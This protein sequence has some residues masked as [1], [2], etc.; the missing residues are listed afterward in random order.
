MKY[1]R[2]CL[3]PDSRPGTEFVHGV[4]PAC[5]FRL[6]STKSDWQNRKR[7]LKQVVD[8][9]KSVGHVSGHDSILGV[10]GGKDSTRLALFARDALGLNPLLVSVTY[11]PLQMT[12]V[13]ANNLDNLV[14]LG[15]DV[16]QTSPSPITWGKFMRSTFLESANWAKSTEL[17]LFSG[18]PQIAIEN[19]IKLI[20]WG[21]N[22][23][24]QLGALETLGNE[25]WDGNSLR[26]MNTLRG[27]DRD[28]LLGQN[29]SRSLISPYIYPSPSEFE[30]HS[31]QI[32]FLGWAMGNWG[33][34]ENGLVA[35]LAGLQGRSDSPINTSDLLNITSLDEDW[36]ILNQMIKYYKYGFGRATDYVNEW[37]RA[38]RLTRVEGIALVQKYDGACADQYIE[39]FSKF[40]NITVEEFWQTVRK[41]TNP[42]LFDLGSAGRPQPLFKVGQS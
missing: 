21:E 9:R 10:S 8:S 29:V 41:F 3:Q 6:T 13:G 25:G 11:P 16:Y 17:A 39:S 30:L 12:K 7:I 18:V 20:L 36:V 15:F 1:C 31:I 19:G 23:G 28:W 27:M 5:E 4:C 32:V 2:R 38:G 42:D 14:R 33:L 26:N 35:G 24:L 40:I 34:L 22:P 37:I